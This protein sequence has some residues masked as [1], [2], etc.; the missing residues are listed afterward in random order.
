[1]PEVLVVLS[2]LLC[3]RGT[4]LDLAMDLRGE[5]RGDKGAGYGYPPLIANHMVLAYLLL[6]W[7]N[8]LESPGQ[9]QLS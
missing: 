8:G 1:M 2:N 7:A 6:G 9:G 5:L 3:R 4:I